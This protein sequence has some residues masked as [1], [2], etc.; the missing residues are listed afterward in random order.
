LNLLHPADHGETLFLHW[1]ACRLII[2]YSFSLSLS[3]GVAF[4]LLQESWCFALRGLHHEESSAT[5]TEALPFQIVSAHKG[6]IICLLGRILVP[7]LVDD[8]CDDDV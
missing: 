8:H 2:V 6:H 7:S 1:P 3:V 4:A 5:A